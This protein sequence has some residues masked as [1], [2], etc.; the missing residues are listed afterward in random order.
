MIL[1]TGAGGTVGSALIAELRAMGQ[2]PRVAHRSKAKAEEARAAGLDAVIVDFAK[3]ETLPPA[4]DGIDAVFLLGTG[5]V[6]QMEGEIAVVN[7]AKAAGAKKVVKLSV[8]R[9]AEEGYLLAKLHRPI[10]RA[11]EASGLAWTFLRPNGFM[12]NFVNYMAGS[13]KAQGAFYQPAGDAKISHIDVRDIARVAALALTTSGHEGK[14]YELSGPRALSYDE[15]AEVLSGVLGKKVSY[16][17]VSDDA[18]KAGMLASGMPESYADHIID[19]NRFYRS[20]AGS[21]VTSA[22]QDVTGRPPIAFE[23][24]ARDHADAFR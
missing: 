23:Q 5:G 20:G 13:I 6:G 24:F 16:V 19:L 2:K 7:A 9:A 14:A 11:V 12:Q 1:V 8:L 18:A 17:A 10:E 15:A 3:P 22:V 21:L 4:L